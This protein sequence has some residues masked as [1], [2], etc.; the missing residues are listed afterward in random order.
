[1]TQLIEGVAIGTGIYG[2]PIAAAHHTF[3]NKYSIS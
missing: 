3:I 1:M 2:Q